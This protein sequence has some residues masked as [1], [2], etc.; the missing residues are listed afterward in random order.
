M[1]FAVISGCL[2]Y[3]AVTSPTAPKVAI[4]LQGGLE[5]TNRTV[6][7]VTYCC[8]F[9][10]CGN[11][12]FYKGCHDLYKAGGAFS[13]HVAVF[14]CRTDLLCHLSFVESWK[15]T[16]KHKKWL[17]GPHLHRELLDIYSGPP[18]D[19][20]LSLYYCRLCAQSREVHNEARDLGH[21]RVRA[22]IRHL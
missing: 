18:V 14:E 17:P 7:F 1:C 11:Y 16:G 13:F 22:G 20:L 9:H 15:L 12:G 6:E 21:R 4:R 3:T 2:I 5:Y 10:G 19:F 8:D